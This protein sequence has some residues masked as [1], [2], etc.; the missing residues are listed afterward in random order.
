MRAPAVLLLALLSSPAYCETYS[1]RVVR[2]ADGDTITV[3]DADNRQRKVRLSGI[4]APEKRQAFG[5]VSKQ[6]LAGLVFGRDVLI[7]TNNKLDQ[8]ERELVLIRVDGQDANLAQVQ[9][10][11]AW[12]YKKYA[13]EQL[14]ADRAVYAQAEDEARAARWGLWI[15][16][17]PVPPWVFRHKRK[18]LPPQSK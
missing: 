8:F 3:L 18:A 7:E 6:H 10:G 14:P 17:D 5:T 1:G 13:H 16:P 9:A 12:H 4:D 15:D 11:L 2:I